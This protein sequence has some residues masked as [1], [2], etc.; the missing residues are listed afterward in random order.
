MFNTNIAKELL[1]KLLTNKDIKYCEKIRNMSSY[2]TDNYATCI[3]HFTESQP[4]HDACNE[5][6]NSKR[7]SGSRL[8]KARCLNKDN[9]NQ[10][11]NGKPAWFGAENYADTKTFTWLKSIDADPNILSSEGKTALIE[12]ITWRGS[13]FIDPTMTKKLL[14][15]GVSQIIPWKSTCDSLFCVNK[16]ATI[17]PLKLALTV[18]AAKLI[19]PVLISAEYPNIDSKKIVKKLLEDDKQCKKNRGDAHTGGTMLCFYKSLTKH[20][21]CKLIPEKNDDETINNHR[22]ICEGSLNKN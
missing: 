5:I 7:I 12:N 3:G 19:A 4:W 18:R 16:I 21:L 2:I 17:T 14:D 13:G 22:Q 20:R 10:L 15:F 6:M 9:V 1:E 8:V 11:F